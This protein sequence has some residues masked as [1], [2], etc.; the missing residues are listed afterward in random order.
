MAIVRDIDKSIKPTLK[1]K[2]TVKAK[3]LKA[4]R[5]GKFKQTQELLREDI[6]ITNS[7]DYAY[8]CL[9]VLVEISNLDREEKD[10]LLDNYVQ[11]DSK[12][13]I[14]Y[15][16]TKTSIKKCIS[17]VSDPVICQNGLTATDCNDNK[18]MSFK[19]IANLIERNL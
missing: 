13:I 9:G 2:K 11:L 16:F 8:C 15:A 18:K 1:L 7:C 5:S 17:D 14:E 6:G 12:E 19:Q 10:N 4:L 3:W